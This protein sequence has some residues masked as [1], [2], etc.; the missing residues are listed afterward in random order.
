MIT[1]DKFL[2]D[3]SNELSRY[4]DALLKDDDNIGRF[5]HRKIGD[6]ML[7]ALAAIKDIQAISA[8]IDG[9]YVTQIP[10][11]NITDS[12]SN[13]LS[14]TAHLGEK[15]NCVEYTLRDDVP[16]SILI[17]P[18]MQFEP[19]ALAN[20]RHE[21][22]VEL[23]RRANAYETLVN[24]IYSLQ[25]NL[26]GFRNSVDER[27]RENQ[28]LADLWLAERATYGLSNTD[29][30]DMSPE[31]QAVWAKYANEREDRRNVDH[32]ERKQRNE[33]RKAIAA[34][35]QPKDEAQ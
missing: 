35:T 13:G 4:G 34:Q 11:L 22:A 8:H 30:S 12:S 14:V 28:M 5:N 26:K 6:L 15:F 17:S 20:K 31:L 25:E 1:N 9:A 29:T 18:W 24:E 10:K 33:L 23:V 21:I 3:L 7:N 2:N 32:A 16:Q 27:D 19:I